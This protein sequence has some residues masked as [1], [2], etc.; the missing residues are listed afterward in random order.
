VFKLI[1][2]SCPEEA[3]DKY[4]NLF[5]MLL[6]AKVT[7]LLCMA[8]ALTKWKI[9]KYPRELGYFNKESVRKV[10][11]HYAVQGGAS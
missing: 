1:E 8:E 6:P 4:I 5:S 9:L 10:L 2:D 3:K 7:F 11:N